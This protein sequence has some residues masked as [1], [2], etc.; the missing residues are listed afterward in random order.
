MAGFG[1]AGITSKGSVPNQF[2]LQRQTTLL[3]CVPKTFQSTLRRMHTW[4][5]RND[6]NAAV[7]KVGQVMDRLPNTRGM[8]Y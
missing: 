5:A 7:A 3:E 1:V 8:I 4:F 2:W 6:C